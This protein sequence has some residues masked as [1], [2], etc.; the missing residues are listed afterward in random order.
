MFAVVAAVA[1]VVAGVAVAAVADALC[2]GEGAVFGRGLFFR[3]IVRPLA[4]AVSRLLLLPMRAVNLLG[5]LHS[6]AHFVDR[7]PQYRL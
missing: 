3:P 2:A 5:P 7:F 4:S 6:A 1:V